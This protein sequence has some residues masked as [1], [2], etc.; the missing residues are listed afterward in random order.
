MMSGRE[1]TLTGVSWRQGRQQRD[2]ERP[3]SFELPWARG[4]GRGLGVGH[5]ARPV[6]DH[7]GGEVRINT[8]SWVFISYSFLRAARSSFL[9]K[10]TK[11][12]SGKGRPPQG[13]KALRSYV[14][15][16][17]LSWT[18]HGR[19]AQGQ[20]RHKNRVRPPRVPTLLP[21]PVPDLQAWTTGL[22]L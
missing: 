17:R 16:A 7:L 22:V 18:G 10:K 20:A 19:A 4:S 12:A 2:R 3:H 8:D 9:E 11:E 1:L 15:P 6:R 13:D 21:C 14:A 5:L